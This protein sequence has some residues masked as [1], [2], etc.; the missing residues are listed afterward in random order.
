[1]FYY[2]GFVGREF[3]ERVPANAY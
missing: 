3:G 2:I 1:L